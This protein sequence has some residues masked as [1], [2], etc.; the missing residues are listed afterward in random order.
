MLAT[1]EALQGRAAAQQAAEDELA[2]IPPVSDS[3]AA[4]FGGKLVLDRVPRD[5]P[6]PDAPTE[7]T[8]RRSA[9]VRSTPFA[10]VGTNEVC[11]P[12]SPGSCAAL[13]SVHDRPP[14]HGQHWKATQGPFRYTVTEIRMC[15]SCTESSSPGG[16][17]RAGSRWAA[18]AMQAAIQKTPSAR[19]RCCIWEQLL[20]KACGRPVLIALIS[21]AS[22]LTATRTAMAMHYCS[23]RFRP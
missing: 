19:G 20:C 11:L 18:D 14:M 9:D 15:V 13:G 12:C 10:R 8:R 2:D 6:P 17:R 5:P 7:S 1:R 4:E 23:A 21:T 22:L 3:V 16:C